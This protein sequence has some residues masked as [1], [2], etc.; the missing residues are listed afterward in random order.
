MVL[1]RLYSSYLTYEGLK[2]YRAILTIS[3]PTPIVS[4][5]TYEGL[6]HSDPVEPPAPLAVVPYL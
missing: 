1:H 5:L 6:K 4:Y 2:L 3:S